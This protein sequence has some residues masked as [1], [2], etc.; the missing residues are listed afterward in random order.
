MNLDELVIY[1]W[2]GQADIAERV[3]RCVLNLGV[4]SALGVAGSLLVARRGR[5]ERFS[6]E[7]CHVKA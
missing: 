3:E 7:P 1:V 2:A 5:S 6:C 4:A